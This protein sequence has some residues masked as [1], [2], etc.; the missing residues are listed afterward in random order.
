MPSDGAVRWALEA[1]AARGLPIPLK[2]GIS[3]GGGEGVK[4]AHLVTSGLVERFDIFELSEDRVRKG[5]LRAAH[6][7]LSD[8]MAFHSIDAFAVDKKGVYDLVHW[9]NALHHMLDVQ[10]AI[11][12]SHHI[13]S[14]RGLFYMDDF[15]GPNRFQWSDAT[16]RSAEL[17]RTSLPKKYLANPRAPTKLLPTEIQRVSPERL[18]QIDPTE[19]ADSVRIVPAIRRTFPAAQVK[20]TGGFVYLIAL[21]DVIHNFDET[22]P[23]DRTLLSYLLSLDTQMTRRTDVES[24]YAG[25]LAFRDDVAPRRAAI[26]AEKILHR[27]RSNF[28]DLPTELPWTQ[29]SLRS[30]KDGVMQVLSSRPRNF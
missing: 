12:W 1:A 10:E 27:A 22:D 19:A 17:I 26:L 28:P 13:L 2:R 21:N 7:G 18:A 5:R 8:R 16:L 14:S 6:F 9:N 15:V 29:G 11:L 24:L 4:E 25:C 30:I 3:V 23:S 20:T